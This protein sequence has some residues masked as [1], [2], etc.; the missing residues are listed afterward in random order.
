MIWD[1]RDN[2]ERNTNGD[3]SLY[4]FACV[5]MDDCM[6]IGTHTHVCAHACKSRGLCLVSS[7]FTILLTEAGFQGYLFLEDE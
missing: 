4:F 3:I 7:S 5:C 1:V 2:T 6:Y